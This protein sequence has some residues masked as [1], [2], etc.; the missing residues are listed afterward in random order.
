MGVEKVV[1]RVNEVGEH[2]FDWWIDRG[3]RWWVAKADRVLNAH[4]LIVID[5][6]NVVR[7]A[8]RIYGVLK[9]IEDGSG[10]VSIEVLP[11]EDSP[12][13]GKEIQRSKSRNPVA[14]MSDIEVISE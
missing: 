4:E 9:D 6:V 10:R 3:R 1:I 13:L 2:E 8:G 12:L 14:Y 5:S 7:A 11:D